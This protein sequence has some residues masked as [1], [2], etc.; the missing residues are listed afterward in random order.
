MSTE[1][2][3]T[4]D[5]LTEMVNWSQNMAMGDMLPKQYRGK[6]ANLMFAAE[7]ADSLG[8]SRI[9]ALTSIHV[10]EGK[11]SAS[12]DLMAAMV[13][14]AGHK[15]RVWDDGDTAHAHLI[16]HDDPDFTFEATFSMADAKA[17]KLENKDN[18]KKYGPSMRLARAISKVVRMGAQDVMAGNIY[19]PEELGADVDAEGNP[20]PQKMTATRQDQPAPPVPSVPQQ[21]QDQAS[22]LMAHIQQQPQQVAQ[23]APQESQQGDADLRGDFEAAKETGD[24]DLALALMNQAITEGHQELAQEIN[25]WG[26]DMQQ[27]AQQQTNT[28]QPEPQPSPAMSPDTVQEVLNAEIVS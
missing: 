23:P 28:T 6:P 20:L 19:T 8:I 10:I 9:H 5:S 27:L 4:Q 11:P 17:A 7:Y 3:R 14:K 13:R 25:Q 1:I 22:R 21:P 24:M 12:S 26:M 2:A 18:W 15:L 16:R